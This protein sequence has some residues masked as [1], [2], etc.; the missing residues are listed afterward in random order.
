MSLTSC[1]KYCYDFYEQKS[2]GIDEAEMLKE[3]LAK[4]N[5]AYRN[6]FKISLK[7]KNTKNLNLYAERRTFVKAAD[8]NFICKEFIR[9]YESIDS[10]SDSHLIYMKLG[11]SEMARKSAE[12]NFSSFLI[13]FI[14]IFARRFMKYPK[15]KDT[16]FGLGISFETIMIAKNINN[17]EISVQLKKMTSD[18]YNFLVDHSEIVEGL[19]ENNLFHGS[20][21]DF[22]RK[23]N[24]ETNLNLVD[25]FK[26]CCRKYLEKRQVGALLADCQ[27]SSNFIEKLLKITVGDCSDSG[28]LDIISLLDFNEIVEYELFAKIAA[29]NST[30]KIIEKL[31]QA[32]SRSHFISDSR[33]QIKFTHLLKLSLLSCTSTGLGDIFKNH[34]K[35]SGP[36]TISSLCLISCFPFSLWQTLEKSQVNFYY[37]SSLIS[38]NLFI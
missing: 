19:I 28:D 18:L 20:D 22:F 13:L 2:L 29:N 37:Y 27:D 36:F 16:L 32:W 8:V 15:Y 31:I 12:G 25:A 23:S 26:L 4:T 34:I 9:M 14:Q 21:L 24:L 35:L 17:S 33:H 30:E 6:V 10:I 5:H 38:K 3:V 11:F 1:L 7:Y